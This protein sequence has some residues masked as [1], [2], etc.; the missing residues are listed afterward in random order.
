MASSATPLPVSKAVLAWARISA[1]LTLEQAEH[2]AGHSKEKIL[3]WERG[4]GVPS[5]PQLEDLAYKA[6]KRPIALFFLAEPPAEPS[7]TQDFRNL[8]NAE[9]EHLGFQTRIALRKAKHVQAL[10]GELR[11]PGERARLLEFKTTTKEDPE[12]VAARFR[13]FIDLPIATQK[14]FRTGDNVSQFRP[15][16]EAMGVLVL[17]LDMPLEEARAFALSGEHPVIVLNAKDKENAQLFSLFHEVCHLLFN[18]SGVFRDEDGHLRQEYRAVEDYCNRFAAAFLVPRDALLAE[19]K[20][21]SLSGEW[22]DAELGKL[23]GIFKVSREVIY[24][25][26][27]ALNMADADDLW[28]RRRLWAAQAKATSK[29]KNEKLKEKDGGM[30]GWMRTRYE[31]GDLFVR[32]VYDAYAA[33]RITLADVSQYLEVKVEQVE[34]LVEEV[35]R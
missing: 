1:G 9:A 3:A 29:E 5:Y 34:R 23:A 26:L 11:P 7:I 19:V 25:Q 2:K 8:T 10:M 35:Y 30:P 21:L 24:R 27:V 22:T 18:T 20:K 16:V 15:F 12:Q 28:P 33:D 13:S 32:S 4:E 6:Y 14:Q 31:K 17:K